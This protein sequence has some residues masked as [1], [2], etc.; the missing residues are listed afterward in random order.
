MKTRYSSRADSLMSCFWP[1]RHTHLPECR[2]KRKICAFE[3]QQTYQKS[4]HRHQ[5]L[6]IQVSYR[7][8]FGGRTFFLPLPCSFTQES[9][10]AQRRPWTPRFSLAL[11]LL[12]L[13]RIA[14]AM[15]SNINDC[16]EGG[17]SLLQ[18][19][20][21]CIDRVFLVYNFWEPLHFLGQGYGFQTW[22]SSPKYAL[23]SWAYILLHYLPPRVGEL[24]AS[25]DK[26][27]F[28]FHHRNSL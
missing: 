27:C 28:A 15:Y 22:E 26:V 13:V 12:F 5:L 19:V 24:L 23:R 16:D 25:G 2:L 18:C 9:Y 4:Q 20:S 21:F 3:N 7:T 17:S 10:R 1:P 8:S 11:R 14:G 6:V